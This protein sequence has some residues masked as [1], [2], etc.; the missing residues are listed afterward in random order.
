MHFKADYASAFLL[1]KQ[2]PGHDWDVRAPER[3]T[4]QDISFRTVQIQP[5][6]DLI[7]KAWLTLFASLLFVSLSNV[8]SADETIVFFRHAEKPEQGLG[9]LSCQGLNRAMKLP[10]SLHTQFGK[11]DALFAPNPGIRKNDKGVS[12]NYIRPLATIEPTAIQA[13]MPVNTDLGFKDSDGLVKALVAPQYS[14]ATVFVAWEHYF[15][16][17]ASRALMSQFDGDPKVVPKWQNSDFDSIYVVH[18]STNADGS[19][20]ATFELKHEGLNNQS[21]TCGI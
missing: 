20:K 10:A 11:P 7:M 19:R 3:Y 2:W 12:Y 6:K 1:L 15:A 14:N 8:A 4:S 16:M 18:L 21:E 17:Q 9:Q 5:I 13:G